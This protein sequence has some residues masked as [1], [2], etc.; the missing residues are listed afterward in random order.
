MR[1]SQMAGKEIVNIADGSRLGVVGHS[2][3]SIDPSTGEIYSLLLPRRP[4]VLNVW[5]GQ[6]ELVVPWD[7]VRKVG[8]EVIVVELDQTQPRLR[9]FL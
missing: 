8:T 5:T 1:L 7:A 6:Q 2:D 9:R 4:N 3:I